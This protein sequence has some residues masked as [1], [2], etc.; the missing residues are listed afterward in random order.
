MGCAAHASVVGLVDCEDRLVARVR[1]LEGKWSRFVPASELNQL[2]AS[3]GSG[4][5]RVSEDT[6][7]LV[8]RSLLAWRRTGGLF[9]PTV[10][11]AMVRLGY[12]RTFEQLGFT[13]RGEPGPAAQVPGCAGIELDGGN[14]M[15]GLP[16]G[17][18]L[19]PGGIG[20]G[21][22]ADLVVDELADAG[23]EGVM[24]CLGGDVRVWG[25]PP[26]GD[27]WTVEV[28]HPT[29]EAFRL[30]AIELTDGAVTTS[31]V[32][33]RRWDGPD[34]PRHHVLDPRT[35]DVARTDLVQV[36]V[37]AARGWW[38]E[39]L[40]TASL[41]AGFDGAAALLAEWRA[42]ALLRTSGGATR[43]VGSSFNELV[44]VLP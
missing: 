2:N 25:C 35:G 23:A 33:Y 17:V 12:D 44:E 16:A 1:A 42:P 36:S 31:S 14:R 3:A 30:G 4:A 20:K 9:D 27:Y 28:E 38:A 39:A 15:V 22:A 6:Y 26:A 10:A 21:L 29:E 40:S 32:C 24:V 7:S 8:E 41:V 11:T 19:D 37:A 18:S 43:L 13:A 5:M 34:G